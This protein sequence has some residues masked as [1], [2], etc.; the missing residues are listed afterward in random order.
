MAAAK[1]QYCDRMSKEM[2]SSFVRLLETNRNSF[3][4]RQHPGEQRSS[5]QDLQQADN[6]DIE[7]LNEEEETASFEKMRK[8][9]LE[10]AIGK[11]EAPAPH[12]KVV[13]AMVTIWV[14][15][16]TSI[17][18]NV[19]NSQKKLIIGIA[20]NINLLF[21]YGAPLSTIFSVLKN[22]DSSS[23]HRWTMIL[24]TANASFWTAFGFG[25]SDYFIM[26]PNGIGALLGFTQMF[27]TMII[28]HRDNTPSDN[29][30]VEIANVVP[31]TESNETV[32]SSDAQQQKRD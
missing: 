26:V 30:D 5:V 32:V 23:I 11:T 3:V 22:R 24:N 27:L 9:A 10:I 12:E 25:T 17:C 18:M 19:E 8:L 29:T 21:F 4:I 13:V 28:P 20:V 15:L 6:F 16:I 2:R 7:K 1:L 14:A 31:S